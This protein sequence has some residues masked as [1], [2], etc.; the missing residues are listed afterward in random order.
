MEDITHNLLANPQ[1]KVKKKAFQENPILIISISLL[2]LFSNTQ[3]DDIY[4]D[5][6]RVP[7]VEG[8]WFFLLESICTASLI[9]LANPLKHDS[10]M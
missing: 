1:K 10:I 8:I 4:R 7:L 3:K 5:P 2:L 9:D 6:P